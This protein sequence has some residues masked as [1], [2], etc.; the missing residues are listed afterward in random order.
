MKL[1]ADLDSPWGSYGDSEIRIGVDLGYQRLLRVR[2]GRL[3]LVT[4]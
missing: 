3:T 1:A 4:E 2:G